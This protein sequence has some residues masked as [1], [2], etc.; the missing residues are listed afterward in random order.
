MSPFET[1]A[2]RLIANARSLGK[3]RAA[4]RRL[5]AVDPAARWR[6]AGLLWPLFTKG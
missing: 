5:N 4:E 2:A 1:L 3:A 6:Q